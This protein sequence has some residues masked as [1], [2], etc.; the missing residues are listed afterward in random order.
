MHIYITSSCLNNVY[1]LN[2]KHVP[3]RRSAPRRSG[4]RTRGF[5]YIY[6]PAILCTYIHTSL[7]L[8]ISLSIY[9]YI[10]RETYSK[11][12][13]YSYYIYIYIYILTVSRRRLRTRYSSE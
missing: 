4:D 10:E 1:V 12:Y 2:G 13:Y 6:T 11:S 5:V 3:A 7:S 8:Y 9:I